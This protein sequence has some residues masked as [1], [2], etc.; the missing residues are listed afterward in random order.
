M[1]NKALFLTLI[2]GT[3]I[4][5]SACKSDSSTQS[6]S[7]EAIPE[8]MEDAISKLDPE[9]QQRFRNKASKMESEK[10]EIQPDPKAS[11]GDGRGA[12][13]L[14]DSKPSKMPM[15]KNAVIEK[16]PITQL[17]FKVKET[18]LVFDEVADWKIS[19]AKK[20]TFYIDLGPG[21]SIESKRIEI[22]QEALHYNK[23]YSRLENCIVLQTDKAACFTKALSSYATEWKLVPNPPDKR[24]F[25]TLSYSDQQKSIIPKLSL[26][27]IK[28][29]V[30]ANCDASFK[31]LADKLE[32]SALADKIRNRIHIRLE[33]TN[34]ANKA[35]IV[36]TLIF[37][38][39]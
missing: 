37:N 8:E 18:T 31:E 3:L 15:K 13:L 36:Q 30:E 25:K 26:A 35:S 39:P 16:A 38:L 9:Q 22:R 27:Q 21:E 32:K 14:E 5:F 24:N 6:K 2:I 34:P 17:K 12:A 4:S 20:D 28:K 19:S 1:I 10:E 11:F 29:E 7:S 33:A 23:V